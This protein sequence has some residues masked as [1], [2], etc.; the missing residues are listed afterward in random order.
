MVSKS[1]S[2]RIT[3]GL[4]TVILLVS[5][6]GAVLADKSLCAC[7]GGMTEPGHMQS[8]SVADCCNTPLCDHCA[9]D[10]SPPIPAP[11]AAINNLS[12]S[13]RQN[14]DP[15]FIAQATTAS[16]ILAPWSDGSKINT[17]LEVY[18]KIPIYLHLQIIRC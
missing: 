9:I 7:C 12:N 3:V 5:L 13:N 14:T 4:F 16:D 10:S 11:V 2:Y 17:P 8:K 6:S 1:R 18:S 15:V